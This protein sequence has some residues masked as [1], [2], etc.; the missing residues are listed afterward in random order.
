MKVKILIIF[1]VSISSIFII[2]LHCIIHRQGRVIN[3][4]LSI[5]FLIN[6]AE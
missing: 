5:T 4:N 3:R 1:Y 2:L 6:K